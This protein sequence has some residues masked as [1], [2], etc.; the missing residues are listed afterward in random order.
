MA[1]RCSHC[2]ENV[3]W[4]MERKQ[5]I[6]TITRRLECYP[7]CDVCGDR[8]SYNALGKDEFV[9]SGMR[10]TVHAFYCE[11]HKPEGMIRR[12]G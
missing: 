1:I 2:T 3:F 8:P 9:G 11:R 6:H 5:W 7:P 12:T 4:E 10:F